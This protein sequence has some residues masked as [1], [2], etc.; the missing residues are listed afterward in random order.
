L[1]QDLRSAIE[2]IRAVIAE[3][4]PSTLRKVLEDWHPADI[5]EVLEHLEPREQEVVL[6]AFDDEVAA[7]VILELP[8]EDQAR[9]L[10]VLSP[11]RAASVLDHMPSDDIADL[12]GDIEEEQAQSIL[13][14]LARDDA[15]DV[16][17]LLAYQD[18]T[19]GGIMTTEL[20]ALREDLT[21]EEAIEHLRRIAPDAETIYYVYVVDA[22]DTLVG[23]LSLRDLII[24]PPSAAIGEIMSTKVIAVQAEDDQEEVARVV[25]RYDLLAVP[26]VNHQGRLMGIVTVDD[27]IDVI[28]EEATEDIHRMMAA[29]TEEAE[30]TV[31]SK[32]RKRLPWLVLLLIGNVL[33]A[34]VLRHYSMA[35]ESLVAL[36]Y[37]VPI[38]MDQSGNV[39]VQ[40]LTVVVRGLATGEV[41]ARDVWRII[42]RELRVGLLLGLFTGSLVAGVA[43]VWQGEPLLGLVIGLAMVSGLTTAALMGTV[44][45]LVFNRLGIDP[46]VASGPFIT[47]AADVTGLLIYFG[48]ASILLGHLLA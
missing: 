2:R 14:L 16:R 1:E 34:S 42:S 20:I 26:V 10:S 31:W 45:P 22:E 17:R 37:F 7:S 8:Y 19:A 30:D 21:V 35:I 4:G 28:E 3:D 13:R 36:A 12:L 15:V 23:V 44:V 9:L 38:L 25:A 46:A 27:V 39:G 41:Q 32:V 18:D 6:E 47:T 33:S 43:L 24:A 29:S 48:L 5:A 11:A 40:S